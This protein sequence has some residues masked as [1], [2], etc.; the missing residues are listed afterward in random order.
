MKKVFDIQSVKI[1]K[2][3]KIQKKLNFDVLPVVK[4][5]LSVQSKNILKEPKTFKIKSEKENKKTPHKIS[6]PVQIDEIKFH[7]LEFLDEENKPILLD[8]ENNL[9]TKKK[10]FSFKKFIG[11]V[12]VVIIMAFAVGVFV[13]KNNTGKNIYIT[14]TLSSEK[15]IILDISSTGNSR[16]YKNEEYGFSINIPKNTKD[17]IFEKEPKILL[18]EKLNNIVLF[19]QNK[20]LKIQERKNKTIVFKDDISGLEFQM[21][22]SPFTDKEKIVK[23]SRIKQELPNAKITSPTEI[24]LGDSIRALI[25]ESDIEK[26]GK[27]KEIWFIKNGNLYQITTFTNYEITVKNILS[28]LKFY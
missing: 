6:Q 16:N 20:I 25:F 13:Y 18:N 27:M 2:T 26:I 7:P 22:I 4:P 10:S 15:E 28:T 11:I 5:K 1:K 14:Q 3:Q 19:V 8:K 21:F 24:I 17:K 23:S 9:I 12:S